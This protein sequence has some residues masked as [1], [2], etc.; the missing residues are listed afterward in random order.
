MISVMSIIVPSS[1]WCKQ[2][3]NFNYI[4]SKSSLAIIL[5]AQ[6][7]SLSQKVRVD[8]QLELAYTYVKGQ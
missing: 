5:R 1:D 8:L 4:A 7:V 6:L 2:E 3:I